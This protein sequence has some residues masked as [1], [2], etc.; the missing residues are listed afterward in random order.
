MTPRRSGRRSG[1]RSA[2][3]TVRLAGASTLALLVG[4][5]GT[6]A[7]ATE[8]TDPIALATWASASGDTGGRPFVVVDKLGA[9]VLAFDGTGSLVAETPALLGA[10]LGDESPPGIGTMRLADITPALRITPAGRYEAHLGVNLSGKTILWIDYDDA[11]SLHSVVTSNTKERR[12]QRLATPATQ[13]NR[14]SYGC[15]NVP[16]WFYQDVVQPLFSP[17]NGIVYIL[18]ETATFTE[19]LIASK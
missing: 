3:R 12:L 16:A 7:Q 2:R 18:P 13:D 6:V 11:L 9:R 14:I 15:I 8:P 10:G 19:Q 17:A 5:A 4:L 1:P